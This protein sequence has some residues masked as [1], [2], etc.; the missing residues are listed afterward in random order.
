M[1]LR[2]TLTDPIGG[3]KV[4]SEP[5]GWKDSVIGFERHPDFHSLVEFFN[6]GF[7]L[8]GSNGV[9]D[10]G[11]DWVL[12]VEAT[13]GADASIGFLAEIDYNE[14][15]GFVT[16]FKGQ[17]PIDMFS[18]S[19]DNNHFLEI[20]VTQQEFWL[21]FINRL[22][23]QVD[24]QSNQNVTEQTQS[25]PGTLAPVKYI[26]LPLPGQVIDKSYNAILRFNKTVNFSPPGI[27]DGSKLY[28]DLIAD[29]DTAVLDE[30]GKTFQYKLEPL[31][32]SDSSFPT[33]PFAKFILEE[34][35]DFSIDDFNICISTPQNVSPGTI[36]GNENRNFSTKGIIQVVIQINDGVDV[37]NYATW[38]A[39]ASYVIGDRIKIKAGVSN[40][41]YIIWE[42]ITNANHNNPP[43]TT[44]GF[45]KSVSFANMI[46]LDG[47]DDNS[48]PNYKRNDGKNI[49]LYN[50]T[51]TNYSYSG[52]F[53]GLKRN[54]SV[55]IYLR[56][57]SINNFYFWD[58]GAASFSTNIHTRALFIWG[59]GGWDNN[60]FSSFLIGG[61]NFI[62]FGFADTYVE[63]RFTTLISDSYDPN[64]DPRR[65]LITNLPAFE[66][67]AYLLTVILNDSFIIAVPGTIG[68][69]IFA[70]GVDVGDVVQ[71]SSQTDAAGTITCNIGSPNIVGVGTNFLVLNPGD[72]IY[73]PVVAG[74]TR[75]PTYILGQVLTIIDAT[76][77]ILAANATVNYAGKAWG[78]ATFWVSHI[79]LYNGLENHGKTYL[80]ATL[81]SLPEDSSS[82]L[83]QAITSSANNYIFN[84]AAVTAYT[85]DLSLYVQFDANNTGPVTV[86]IN[87][88]GAQAVKQLN[89]NN[90]VANDIISIY[91]T[92]GTN[93]Y[94]LAADPSMIA[95]IEGFQMVVKF[96]NASTGACTLN[97]NGLGAKNLVDKYGN[98]L[99]AGSIGANEIL[100]IEYDGVNII[101]VDTN[102]TVVGQTYV[103]DYNG[104]YFTLTKISSTTNINP[105]AAKTVQAFLNHDVMAGVLDRITDFTNLFYS[106]YLGNQFTSRVY[107][108]VGNGSLLAIA[109]GLHVRGFKLNEKQFFTSC[110]DWWDGIDPILNLGLGYDVIGGNNVIR[111][112]KKSFFYDSSSNSI[113]LS[114]VKKI[115]RIYDADLQFNQL[116]F[117]YAKWESVSENGVGISSGLDDP[118][119]SQTRNTVFRN[120]GKKFSKLSN[121]IA[122]SLTIEATRRQGKVKTGNYTYD[123]DTF[124]IS[125]KNNGDGTFQPEL[126]ENIS[127]I[128][129]LLNPST[130]YN[131]WLTPARNF[132]RWLNYTS[133]AMQAY[134][135]TVFRFA[136]G[137][138]NYNATSTFTDAREGSDTGV[139]LAE[140]SDIIPSNAPLH[141]D[142]LYVIEDFDLDWN[143]Y[144]TLQANRHKSIGIS[145]TD[146]GHVPFHIKNFKYSIGKGTV[147]VEAW[148]TEPFTI[149]VPDTD[150]LV[151][152]I[153]EIEFFER[154]EFE[155]T[156]D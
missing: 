149:V 52:T 148:P 51:V 121:W 110:K 156:F 126:D 42:S 49:S 120:I 147:Y 74:I 111:V 135:T 109:K 37:N 41:E 31:N 27:T 89:G 92:L 86:N 14:D 78:H 132:L 95:L 28:T 26:N 115:R 106:E 32:L 29:F 21:Q 105:L 129:G 71:M 72:V 62:P 50:T 60:D 35:G 24:I 38:D 117:G 64:T 83:N 7:S 68:S 44:T 108:A 155:N 153:P 65:N 123:N 128:S 3:T 104:T 45:W 99:G 114:N 16:L 127:A 13:Y 143:D 66:D 96:T 131:I 40:T 63:Q 124:V 90:L 1:I 48:L 17:L 69:G 11:R 30:I 43:S 8:Y 102:N 15:G 33:I 85:K 67:A 133:C 20:S 47:V 107:G 77:L 19:V 53:K 145:Q 87:G 10:G 79:S 136:S 146:S 134:L 142:Q 100:S 93:A 58:N 18:E 81:H 75:D 137:K 151:S 57:V 152:G 112:E 84:S 2:F 22:N 150:S 6:S 36:T 12:N 144:L 103:I 80:N 122:A 9:Q 125:T 94:T 119:A 73:L 59:Q 118:Q 46:V 98:Q 116:E 23:I 130:R 113:L 76:H 140:N 5:A 56:V 61:E 82:D 139:S 54:D 141:L 97:I 4:I 138:G 34:S 154:P 25:L 88:L 70:Q 55:R 91:T 101:V 39:A